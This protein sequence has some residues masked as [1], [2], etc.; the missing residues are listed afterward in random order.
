M[1]RQMNIMD[2]G[3][4]FLGGQLLH[5]AENPLQAAANQLAQLLETADPQDVLVLAGAGLGWHARAA[6]DHDN[7]PKVLIYEPNA[8]QTALLNCLGP[9]IGEAEIVSSPQELA[10]ALGRL[11]VYEA[12]G[13]VAVYSHPAYLVE[14]REFVDTA[15]EVVKRVQS[16]ARSDFITRSSQAE[17]WLSHIATNFK[18]ILDAPDISLPSGVFSNIP[19]VVIG[20]GPSLDNSLNDL[21]KIEGGALLLAAASALAPLAKAGIK[22]HLAVALEAKDES[23]QFENIDPH[24]TVLAAASSS[25]PNHFAL[26]NGKLSTFHL[27]KWLAELTGLSTALPTGGHAT[28]AAFSLA[29]AWGCD[30]IILVGQDLAYTGGRI[31]AAGRPGGEDEARPQLVEVASINGGRVRTSPV[32]Q[33]YI[34]WYREAV[35]YL[36]QGNSSTRVINATAA[37][38]L[39][40]P[41]EHMPLEQ[42]LTLLD[43]SQTYDNLLQE[44]ADR[45]PCP[46]A[47]HLGQGLRRSMAQVR[48][49]LAELGSQG[50]QAARQSAR[51]IS[52]AWP[53]LEPLTPPFDQGEIQRLLSYLLDT[54]RNME[55]D[56]HG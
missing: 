23:R 54:L 34:D 55:E 56:L 3:C 10:E 37:G 40:P 32:M 42:A 51:Q 38:A 36:E 31:H 26:W 4:C 11:L 22:P 49:L 13:K 39:L 18:R 5:P 30:P 15:R 24:G 48:S 29:I 7:G 43:S 9:P 14:N 28:S 17:K 27:Q 33:S 20:A 52:C 8:E 45:L 35:S 21:A 12:P 44:V 25:H 41:M 2:D 53:L 46:P 16:R 19:A 6:L 47:S 50:P 1:N